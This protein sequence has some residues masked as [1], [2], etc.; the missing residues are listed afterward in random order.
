MNF[1]RNNVS[2]D[3]QAVNTE[4]GVETTM[5]IPTGYEYLDQVFTTFPDNSFLCKSVAGVGGTT[6]AINNQEDYV[7]AGSS[8]ELAVNKSD[9]HD[10]LI[11][12]YAGI[13][14]K[15]II[16]QVKEKRSLGI[17]VKII[18]TY[19]SLH[20]VV[21]AL[22]KDVGTFKVL[23]DELQVLLKA[24]DK[25][26][27]S[28]VAKVLSQVELFKSVCFMTATPTPRKYFPPEVAKLDYYRVL[29]EDSQKMMVKKAKVKG[30]I[31]P[32]VTAIALHHLDTGGTPIFFYNSLKGIIP[33]IKNL[34][35]ARGVTHKDI[36]IIC[37]NTDD[38]KSY[39]KE[40]LGKE[41][42][43]EKPLYKEFDK[44]GK[45]YMNPRNKPIQFCTKYAF[46]G[47]DFIVEDSHTYVVSD[48]RNKHR[49]HTRI[50][51]STDLQQV[52]GRCRN[53]NPLVKRECVFL[54]NDSVEGADLSEDD[55]EEFVRSELALAKDMEERYTI[56]KMRSMN[57]K[58]DSSPYFVE[59]DGDV[60]TN[61]YSI[62]GMCI[63]YASLNV[64]YVNVMVDGNHTTRMEEKLNLFSE[65]EGFTLPQLNVRDKKKLD[66]KQN[67]KELSEEYYDV[68]LDMQDCEDAETKTGLIKELK[69]LE[70]LD[71]E[72]SEVLNAIGIEEIKSTYFNKTKSK[73]KYR[74]AVGIKSMTSNKTKSFNNL[75][76]KEG[77]FYT[78]LEIKN[79]IQQSYNKYKI[80]STAKATDI[81]MVY[82]VKRT[83]RNGVEGFL[84]GSKI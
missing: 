32:K 64:D 43:P 40:Q 38:N 2:V 15:D 20:K 71:K 74:K 39:L 56:E 73:T 19:D 69:V 37:A 16:K 33:C 10:N 67:F 29:W 79:N 1:I 3:L 55:Y 4:Q 59:I 53:Q 14:A 49:H 65:T 7:I 17:P 82:N 63:S 47:L 72:F 42:L 27:P 18:V 44:D 45:V 66:R 23:V 83:K 28:V 35:K 11:P 52:A 70:S 57:I 41:W 78:Y 68:Y 75:K 61:D 6:L 22:G 26:K 46:E 13:Y 25:F 21:D 58:F 36:K 8:V 31:T 76:M 81:K 62:Y 9:Q 30:D 77:E 84:L 54:W 51:I 12:V 60:V 48:V 5:T 80:E 24:S 50:D 34:I